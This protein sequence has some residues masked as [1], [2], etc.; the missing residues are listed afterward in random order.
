M[1]AEQSAFSRWLFPPADFSQS[2]TGLRVK[3]AG[4]RRIWML[5]G[6]GYLALAAL[7]LLANPAVRS[8]PISP[9]AMALFAIGALLAIGFHLVLFDMLSPPEVIEIDQAP[10]VIRQTRTYLWFIRRTTTRN[11]VDLRAA[12]IDSE[13][14]RD[15][16][17]KGQG[18][19]AFHPMLLLKND[20]VE[21]LTST[22][23]F[24]HDEAARIV[25]AI[26]DMLV[27]A[28]TAASG[29][30]V[31]LAAGRPTT[32]EQINAAA[33]VRQ[34]RFFT[35]IIGSIIVCGSLALLW[36]G[37]DD[38]GPRHQATVV[39]AAPMC[40][41][42]WRFSKYDFRS[43]RHPTAR[44]SPGR[45]VRHR[46]CNLTS[47]EASISMSVSWMRVDRKCRGDCS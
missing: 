9:R 38:F 31:R 10:K 37:R 43:P 25:A 13:E 21:R 23:A 19:F 36:I 34:E 28:D 27:S 3:L 42:G 4:V 26:N 46:I 40:Q 39:G 22:H 47:T 41:Y 24:S 8:M 16:Y 44:S 33:I 32:V 2:G 6:F 17:G 18:R 14:V 29:P 5:G 20:G 30:A 45:S 11:A 12:D 1:S 15:K 35:R 7:I